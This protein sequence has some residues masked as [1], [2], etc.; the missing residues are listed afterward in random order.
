MRITC[1]C[2]E[3]LVY[4][5]NQLAMALGFSEADGETYF[6]LSWEDAEGNV[7]SAAS[8]D[9]SESWVVFAQKPLQRPAWD[10]NKIID[11]DAANEAQKAMIFYMFGVDE[12]EPKANPL[13][14]VAI[15]GVEG[16]EAISLMGLTPKLD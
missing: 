3:H 14:L 12:N 1:S 7:Y 6:G 4:Q 9:A 5:G 16:F 2:P 11:M 13:N 10:I 15:A 8:F